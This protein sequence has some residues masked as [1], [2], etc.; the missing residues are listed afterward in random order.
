MEE[1]LV[2]RVPEVVALD[3]LRAEAVAGHG[4]LVLL[5]GEPGIGKTAVVEEAVSRAAAA[6]VTV[7]TGRAEPDEGA[8]AYWPW[9]RLLDAGVEG[10]SPALLEVREG[11]GES[12]AAARFRVEHAAAAALRETARRLGGLML[13]LEDLHWADPASLSLLRRLARDLPT[14]GILVIGTAWRMDE[15]LPR[16]D[17]L[18]LGPL[19]PAAVAAFL[20]Q[21][22]GGPVHGTWPAVVHRLGGGNPLYIR[23]LA[24]LLARA[25]RLRR[26]ASPVDLPDGLRRLV[27]RR[28]DQLSPAARDL[29]G[30]AAAL[31]SDVDITVLR[32]AAA[33]PGA[34]DRLLAE[35]VGAGVLIDDPW[36]PSTLRFAHDLVR[37]AR[38]D[39]LTRADRIGWHARIAEALVAAGAPDADVARH[40]VRAAVDASSRRTAVS[41]CVDAARTA[42]H[43][44]DHGEA[45]RWYGRA[46][47]F[48]PGDP[49]LHLARAEVAYR[50]GQL[51]VALADCAAV[52]EHAERR[53]DP[54]LAS[55]AA[56]VVRGVS[57][58]HGTTLIGFC[59]R[60]RDLF[61][62]ADN[63]AHAEVLAQHAFLL[64][65]HGDRTRAETISREAMAMAERSGEPGALVTAIHARHE[66]L[67]PA[68]HLDEVLDL[69]DRTL[70]LRSGRPDAELWAR[71]WRMD[72]LLA[73][74]DMTA[75]DTEVQQMTVLADRLGWPLARYHLLRARAVREL[76]NGRFA[77]ADALGL[78]AREIGRRAQDESAY[79]L[80]LALAGALAAHTGDFGRWAELVRNEA[81]RHYDVPIAAAQIAHCALLM[82]DREFGRASWA[83]LRPAL[84]TL[85]HDGR[86]IF[87][88]AAAGE[89]AAWLGDQDAVRYCYQQTAPYAHLYLNSTTSC[90]GAVA[91]IRGTLA[92]VL[93]RHDDADRQLSEA[94][95]MEERIGATPFVAQAQLAHAQALEARCRPGDRG[96]ARRLAERAAATARRLGANRL[97]SIAG[98]LAGDPLT[99]RE[100][101][102]AELV[103][104]GL[105]NRAIAAKL[106]L[107]ERTVETHVRNVL[108][109][110]GL[111]NRTQ[112]AARLRGPVT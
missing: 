40:R 60:A 52:L 3:R 91:R 86:R 101:E 57:G 49:E 37:Q 45:A 4:S 99:G 82:D 39:D 61:G 104:D 55:R 58:L 93:G 23:E 30:G 66:V 21:Q 112:L 65:E 17:V 59:E 42:A 14:A 90:Y 27:S 80:Y 50:D 34:V 87:T 102:I 48:A 79:F 16:A 26:P 38:Y 105:A 63:D 62:D 72:A 56:L 54:T 1:R 22:A 29:L 69:A 32:A 71:G 46:L 98:R 51:D 111:R 95:R 108:A 28:M 75:V 78:A 84:P 106:V 44:L 11:P 2:G 74:G 70:A 100:R 43:R 110:L 9:S 15:R 103:A 96:R 33:E 77:E 76:L 109:K 73:R 10:L 88:V 20:A 92:S 8:P 13:V 41:S 7:L 81:R 68:T 6:D 47:E 53:R 25:D 36:H 19:E 83:R 24:R 31:G 94:V 64:A 18:H 97:V 35:A 85:H 12:A 5:T 89:V 107:S 67:E